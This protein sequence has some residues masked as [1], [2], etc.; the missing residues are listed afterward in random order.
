MI[1][2]TQFWKNF[3]ND[4]DDIVEKAKTWQELPQETQLWFYMKH[5]IETDDWS[6]FLGEKIEIDLELLSFFAAEKSAPIWD[7][8]IQE[9]FY[10]RILDKMKT[11]IYKELD[12]QYFD[13]F[14][15]AF[16]VTRK[17]FGYVYYDSVEETYHEIT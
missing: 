15:D 2:D 6:I 3:E 7:K 8:T 17:K 11:K 9:K 5:A 16:F 12:S 14:N 1:G 13:L 10:F 4:L